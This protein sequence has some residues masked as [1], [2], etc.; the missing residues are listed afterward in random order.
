MKLIHMQ[1]A[2]S[3]REHSRFTLFSQDKHRCYAVNA[4]RWVFFF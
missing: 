1:S 3:K 4:M 2:D